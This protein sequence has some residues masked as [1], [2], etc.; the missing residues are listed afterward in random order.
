MV[1]FSPDQ[2]S[3][4]RQENSSI[5]MDFPLTLTR[6]S[7]GGNNV[8][9]YSDKGDTKDI[10]E[11]FVI[12]FGITFF[13]AVIFALV[14]YF[15]SCVLCRVFSYQG[16]SKVRWTCELRRVSTNITR[17]N[18]CVF[19]P[20]PVMVGTLHMKVP[21]TPIGASFSEFGLNPNGKDSAD[22]TQH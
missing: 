7:S 6:P 15:L 10:H 13:I 4:T 16:K 12:V 9:L 2:W 21:G 8:V 11:N 20:S 5:V 14:C 19:I 17:V 22:P 3:S 18:V 1:A